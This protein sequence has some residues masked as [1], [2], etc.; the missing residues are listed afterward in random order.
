MTDLKDGDECEL[1]VVPSR[2]AVA[3]TT[4]GRGGKQGRVTTTTEPPNSISP[5]SS[6]TSSSSSSSS[7]HAPRPDA[8]RSSLS[9]ADAARDGGRNLNST[10]RVSTTAAGTSHRKDAHD[11]C[12]TRGGK[13]IR[14]SQ[15][16]AP[17]AS[18][19][20]VATAAAA[21]KD[22]RRWTN[23][24][25]DSSRDD[26][27]LPTRQQ[28]EDMLPSNCGLAPRA[29][30]KVKAMSTRSAFI[31]CRK[32]QWGS[33]LDG[34]RDNQ[35]DPLMPISM[36]NNL[37]TT[38]LH[39]AISSRSPDIQARIKVIDYILRTAPKAAAVKNDY[40]SLPLHSLAQR[41]VKMDSKSKARL[42]K[43]LVEIYP[44]GLKEQGGAKRTPLHVLCTGMCRC[45]R[46]E[47]IVCISVL[48]D[49]TMPLFLGRI[50]QITSR[51]NWSKPWW[52]LVP[53]HAP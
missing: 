1:V 23:E 17:T 39:Q 45:W 43:R 34:L 48:D 52:M 38:V 29:V 20:T 11:F 46:K 12:D 37:T 41:N 53:R 8:I 32:N 30:P 4:T 33:I 19:A 36:A 21:A 5:T 44:A 24:S 28:P 31:M 15:P 16:S 42:I 27:W 7:S 6:S 47:V 35:L 22:D 50:S 13:T 18:K 9:D 49:S 14:S 3:A 2:G 26:E 51:Q 25:G 40:D 10:R